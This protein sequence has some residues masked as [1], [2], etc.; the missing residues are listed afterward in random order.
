M[1]VVDALTSL[2]V[3]NRL[4]EEVR[5][6]ADSLECTHSAASRMLSEED[7][8]LMLQSQV[9][10]RKQQKALEVIR[11]TQPEDDKGR[12]LSIL[13]DVLNDDSKI[14]DATPLEA[15]TKRVSVIGGFL[16]ESMDGSPQSKRLNERWKHDLWALQ[17]LID[18]QS[19]T[20]L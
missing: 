2:E 13:N 15:L 19:Q 7:S 10:C 11:K 12:A 6:A 1:L 5:R 20:K 8:K 18:L 3:L 14:T 9:I 4:L 17:T 16:K